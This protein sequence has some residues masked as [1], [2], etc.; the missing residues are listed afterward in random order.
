MN[1]SAA[2]PHLPLNNEPSAQ[3]PKL[4]PLARWEQYFTEPSLKQMRW[5][6]FRAEHFGIEGCLRKMPGEK[7]RVW[8]DHRAF[9]EILDRRGEPG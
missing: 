7:G 8:I 9:W 1:T 2:E 3:V 6:V 5:M 4:I